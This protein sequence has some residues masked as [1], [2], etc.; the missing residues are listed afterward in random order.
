[1]IE[2]LPYIQIGL[3]GSEILFSKLRYPW[4]SLVG[5]G[6]AA[7]AMQ[8]ELLACAQ[9]RTP[10]QLLCAPLRRTLSAKVG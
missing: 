5:K 1:M 4:K 6:E 8:Q 9:G 7:A 2:A 3:N 10:S